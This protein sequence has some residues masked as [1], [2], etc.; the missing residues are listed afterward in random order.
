[1]IREISKI[2]SEIHPFT[3]HW[4]FNE[5]FFYSARQIIKNLDW[6]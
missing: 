3:I 1:M 5:Y 2:F 4:Y 6:A